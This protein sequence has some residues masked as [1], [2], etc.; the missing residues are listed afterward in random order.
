MDF[1]Y[2]LFL[3]IGWMD[4]SCEGAVEKDEIDVPA[5]IC[6]FYAHVLVCRVDS[7]V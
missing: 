1:G 7:Y 4:R 6:D 2:F 3:V 5:V